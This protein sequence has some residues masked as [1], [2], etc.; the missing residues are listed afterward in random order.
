MLCKYAKKVD[1]IH[2]KSGLSNKTNNIL[3]H[4]QFDFRPVRECRWFPALS[5]GTFQTADSKDSVKKPIRLQYVNQKKNLKKCN[6]FLTPYIIANLNS[7]ASISVKVFGQMYFSRESCFKTLTCLTP[8][9]SLRGNM[10]KQK[11]TK[12]P[13]F[14]TLKKQ[15]SRKLVVSNASTLFTNERVTN[16]SD[17]GTFWKGKHKPS[18]PRRVSLTPPSVL[19]S[20]RHWSRRPSIRVPT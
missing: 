19:A 9:P 5:F 6:T 3:K 2:Q 17:D 8:F 20:E 4:E 13:F 16:K 10:L 15:K 11:L 14:N 1:T 18:C 12:T 7:R